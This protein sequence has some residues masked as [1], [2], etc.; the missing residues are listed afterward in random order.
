MASSLH[1]DGQAAILTT[2]KCIFLIML[3]IITNK[4]LA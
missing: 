3:T 4:A 1:P 2:Q